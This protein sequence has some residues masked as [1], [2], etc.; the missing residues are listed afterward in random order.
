MKRL[1]QASNLRQVSVSNF[2][3]ENQSLEERQHRLARMRSMYI[4][5]C[6]KSLRKNLLSRENAVPENVQGLETKL[7]R[8][9]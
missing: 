9:L 2:A 4:K 3:Y 8:I 7:V 1:N 6:G 5:G